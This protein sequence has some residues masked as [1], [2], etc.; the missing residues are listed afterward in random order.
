MNQYN[1][2]QSAHGALDIYCFSG[3]Q[4][5]NKILLAKLDF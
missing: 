3:E 4:W 2:V 1:R 5:K